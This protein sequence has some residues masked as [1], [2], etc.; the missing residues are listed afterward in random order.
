M[1][2]DTSATPILLNNGNNI[3][4]SNCIKCN[5]NKVSSF[6]RTKCMI[7]I[8]NKTNQKTNDCL[9]ESNQIIV[10]DIYNFRK[11]CVNCTE[12]EVPAPFDSDV[13]TFCFSC[14]EGKIIQKSGNIYLCV[15]K[16]NYISAGERCISQD[17]AN[18]LTSRY[19]PISAR[20]LN[21]KNLDYSEGTSI[22]RSIISNSNA[23][24]GLTTG[25]NTGLSNQLTEITIV[26]DFINYLF[27]DSSY[28][29]LNAD[30]SSACEII[31]NLC[32]LQMYDEANPIC[33]LYNTINNSK[34]RFN[35]TL[36]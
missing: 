4:P 19:P 36:E 27:L 32:V 20:N 12:N 14:G 6:D 26:S 17:Q 11:T 5:N 8:N 18:V 31:A 35:T 9:C 15:C 22:Y 3:I 1:A 25:V 29:C 28:A 13:K 2:N 21:F 23:L 10:E 16:L 30:N 24:S 33:T 7:C 34:D